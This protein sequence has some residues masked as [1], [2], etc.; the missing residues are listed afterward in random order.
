MSD[1]PPSTPPVLTGYEYIKLLGSGGFADVFLY[2]QHHPKRQVAVKVLLKEQTSAAAI[3]GFTEEANLMAQLASHP[4]IVSVFSAGVSP[5]GR[6]YLVMENC[7]R[8]NL[9]TRH[10]RERFS[11]AE[12][13]RVGIQIGSA[14]EAAHRFGILHRDIKPANIL[15]TEYGRPALTDFGIAATTGAHM[16]GMSIPWSPPEVFQSPPQGD[17]TSDV[18][19]LAATLY[20][21]L[22]DRTPFEIPGAPNTQL[23]VISR[24]QTM[25]VPALGRKD[26]SAS[27]EATLQR[28]MAKNPRERYASALEFA[29]ALQ[30][31]QIELGMQETPLDVA[32]EELLSP[33]RDDDDVERTTFRSITSIDAQSLPGMF[34]PTNTVTSTGVDVPLPRVAPP[35]PPP[36]GALAAPPVPDAPAV[37]MAPAPAPEHT[38]LADTVWG[39]PAPSTTAPYATGPATPTPLPAPASGGKKVLPALIGGGAVVVVAIAVTLALL[40]GPGDSSP[41]E[42]PLDLPEAPLDLDPLAPVPPVA[43]LAGIINEDAATFTWSNPDPQDGDLYLWRQIIVGEETEFHKTEEATATLDI[44]PQGQTCIE[45]VLRRANG[46]TAPQPAQGCAS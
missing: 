25:P 1:R 31:V 36:G 33:T 44:N 27:L 6:P 39:A 4:S 12:T 26:V 29:R 15:V 14:I 21:L 45:V 18:Y 38:P 19:S 13:L 9:Q 41:Q 20:T 3:A 10:R 30:R 22:V 5:D 35:P 34:A 24:I 43:N 23:D 11:E 32:E 2:E 16:T 37:R 42:A 17:V 7:P 8:S 28:A 40:G 46:T